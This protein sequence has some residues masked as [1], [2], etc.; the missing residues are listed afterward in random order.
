MHNKRLYFLDWIRIIAF[1]LLILFHTGMYYVTWGWHV[2][3]PN[4]SDA[5]E[6][7][8]MLSSPW[9]MTLLFLVSGVAACHLLD[10]LGTTQFARQRSFRLLVPLVFGMFFIVPPQSYFEV[11]EKLNYAG[12]F[13]DFM[14]LYVTGYH[15]FCNKDGCLTIPTW[16]HLWFLPYLWAYTMILAVV[17]TK[18]GGEALAKLLTGWRLI[19]LPAALLAVIRMTLMPIF[20]TTHDLIHDWA[21]HAGYFSIF[22]MGALLAKQPQFW[23]ATERARFPALGIAFACWACFVCYYSLPES[24]Q[25]ALNTMRTV[26]ALCQW[27]A[28]VAVCGFGRRHLN[29]DSAKRR[30]L[31]EAVFPIYILHQTLIVCFAHS[32]K[33]AHIAPAIEYLVL[34]VL[35]TTTSFG[36][37]EI[38]RRVPLLRPCF[39][40]PRTE[41]TAVLPAA[42]VVN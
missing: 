6:P 41:K 9:R 34:V 20:D 28:I 26:Y 39:G 7:L 38:V 16:N 32:L 37:F 10:K 17:G 18:R 5:I 36:I 11:V 35:T 22:M 8:M 19:V 14:H 13:S 12:S 27:S 21:M 3:S 25:D 24:M 2:K 42:V 29:F 4:A 40:L 23:E 1:F 30:Y 15:G 33:V 31:T